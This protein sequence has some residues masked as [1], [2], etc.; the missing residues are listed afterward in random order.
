MHN[1][2]LSIILKQGLIRSFLSIATSIQR[3]LCVSDI[4]NT[5]DQNNSP[6]TIM[7]AIISHHIISATCPCLIQKQTTMWCHFYPSFDCPHHC[8]L[9]SIDMRSQLCHVTPWSIQQTSW[10]LMCD[11]WMV[12]A[13]CGTWYQSV[14]QKAWRQFQEGVPSIKTPSVCLSWSRVMF[15]YTDNILMN[16]DSSTTADVFS[17][18]NL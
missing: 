17:I 3:L 18:M 12:D 4:A 16:D 10:Q 13:V 9:T 5:Y 8:C 11:G 1:E 14:S 6:L 2:H 7:T 15:L